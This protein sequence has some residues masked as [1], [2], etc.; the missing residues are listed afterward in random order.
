MAA[1]GR[2]DGFGEDWAHRHHS[3]VECLSLAGFPALA[4]A[5]AFAG[6]SPGGDC[7]FRLTPPA[8]PSPAETGTIFQPLPNSRGWRCRIG[9][10]HPCLIPMPR[11]IP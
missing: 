9:I 8:P 7:C 6:Q 10:T 11:T 2:R 5:R 4:I 1:N 3:F